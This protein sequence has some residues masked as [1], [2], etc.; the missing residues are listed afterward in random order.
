MNVILI[1][2]NMQASNI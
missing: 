1:E 2:I